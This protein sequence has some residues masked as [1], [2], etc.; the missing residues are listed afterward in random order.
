MDSFSK[1]ERYRIMFSQIDEKADIMQIWLLPTGA[2]DPKFKA[3]GG[4]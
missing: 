4:K 2:V 1:H 3:N